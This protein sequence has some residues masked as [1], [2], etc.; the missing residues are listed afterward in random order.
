V[1]ECGRRD[2]NPGSQ[3]WK[4]PQQSI[5]WKEFLNWMLKDHRQEHSR[6]TVNYAKKYSH[7]LLGHDFSEV[8]DLK[9]TIRPNAMKA[10]SCLAKYLG[11]YED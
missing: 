10:L 2:L 1:L 8:R 4:S 11:L 6:N 9:E 7:C 3:A 5:D